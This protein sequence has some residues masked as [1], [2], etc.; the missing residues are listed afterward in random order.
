MAEIIDLFPECR[1]RPLCLRFDAFLERVLYH[2]EHGYYGQPDLRFGKLGDFYTSPHVHSFFAEILAEQF[3][4]IWEE[5]GRPKR[6]VLLEMGPGDATLAFQLLSATQHRFREF[7]QAVHYIGLETSAPLAQRQRQKL[8]PFPQARILCEQYSAAEIDPFE[9]CVFSNEFLDALPFR[10]F[11][12]RRGEWLEYVVEVRPDEMAGHWEPT[13]WRPE[14]AAGIPLGGILEWR[15]QFDDLYRFLSRILRRG[16]VFHLDYGDRRENLNV[17]GTLR[18]FYRHQLGDNPFA[19]LGEQDVTAN[20]DFS[21]LI[22]LGR[23]YHFQ[24]R[25]LGQRDYLVE[26]GILEKIALRFKDARPEQPEVIKEKLA[27]KNLIVPGGI[28]DYFK[29]L[30]QEKKGG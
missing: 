17:Q 7:C 16:K 18:T 23:K 14:G 2:K 9:G 26:R 4:Q 30:I 6:F 19:N 20:V 15:D 28:S 11:Q 1:D 12:R 21:H 22:S 5:L 25:L 10:R 24:S 3:L 29:V 8:A 13:D 27:V